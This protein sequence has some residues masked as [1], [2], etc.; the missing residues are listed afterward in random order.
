MTIKTRTFP[1]HNYNSIYV[2]G[3]TL[4]LYIN[5][6]FPVTELKFPEFYDVKLT[7][8]CGGKC[9]YCYQESNPDAKHADDIIN[10]I[11]KYFG[12]MSENE[13]PFQIAFGGGEP[14]MHPQFSEIMKT[15]KELGIAPNYTTNG[16]FTRSKEAQ[17]GILFATKE[18][19]EGVAFSCHEHL[20]ED[21]RKGADLFVEN[22]IF[23]NF[24]NIISD[25]KSVDT[26]AKIYLEY[27]D[28]IKYF[29]LLP[30]IAQ[31]RATENFNKET[32][33]YLKA[34]FSDVRFDMKKIAFGANFY[35]YLVNDKTHNFKVDLYEPEIMSK[36]LDFV[37]MKMYPSSFSK[38]CIK[39]INI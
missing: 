18:Y 1:E 32:W 10:K 21:W 7:D 30:L 14:T 12:T 15:T 24:H 35:P 2:N 9:P 17:D 4:R 5:P 38:E 23:T 39:K 25:K 28:K 29:V 27:A 20:D 3:K 34:V 8:V 36:Y 13:K 6:D 16:T 33:D 31:G 11:Q 19:C 26:F 37:E 22:G